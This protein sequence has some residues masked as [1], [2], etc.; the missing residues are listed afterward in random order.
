MATKITITDAGLVELVNAQQSGTESVTLTHI[1]FGTGQ[2]T[3][4]A[5]QTALQAEIKRL[6]T[7]A[8]G[9]VD[10]DVIHLTVLDKSTD[11][12]TANEFGVFTDKGTLFAVYSQTDPIVQKAASSQA[13]LAIDIKITGVDVSS[14]TVGDTTFVVPPATTEV[15]G[16][17]ELATIDE[18][19]EGSDSVRAVTPSGLNARV[20]VVEHFVNTDV[21]TSLNDLK[22]RVTNNTLTPFCVNQGPL[23]S[24]GLPN[25]L[26]FANDVNKTVEVAFIQPELTV[27]GTLGGDAFAVLAN[28][29][30][31]Y[32]YD[33][34]NSNDSY[35]A[36]SAVPSPSAPSEITIYNPTALKLASIDFKNSSLSSQVWSTIK[37]Q[38]S[39]DNATWY[40]LGTFNNSI[41]TAS[42]W[43]SVGIDATIAYKYFKLSFTVNSANAA[44]AIA[45]IRLNA[46]MSQTITGGRVSFAGPLVAT[47]AQGEKFTAN[48]IADLDLSNVT[49]TT[50]YVYLTRSGAPTYTLGELH[51]SPE[52]PTTFATDDIWF[53]TAEPLA[54]YQY[55]A[56]QWVEFNRAPVGEVYLDGT[57]K[58]TS[59]STYPY[60]QNGY[61]VNTNTVATASTF[62]LVRTASVEDTLNCQCDEATVTPASLYKMANFRT[63]ETEYAEG[64]TVGCPFHHNWYLICVTS[65][66]TSSESLDCRDVAI[67]QTIT[68]GTVVW[69]VRE[70]VR[71]MVI[72]ETRNRDTS[73]PTYG[74]I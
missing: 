22:D 33:A 64:D 57:G 42:T 26:S 12:Y 14:I 16:L 65:G 62:G 10:Q 28:Q 60:N 69:E 19:L 61:T 25:I 70:E 4:S 36:G 41:R 34:F 56:G 46:T 67:G 6:D 30:N 63:I 66:T 74:L 73:K 50:V 72:G 21:M 35:W 48:T 20:G 29:N 71:S 44:I 38:A 27:N 3:P 9:A 51:A 17:V 43:V 55:L 68:D 47:T 2:Y 15:Q 53:K 11:V 45:Q 58:I 32:I 8:G 54:S 31:N 13:M 59:V 18:A 7:I 5:S 40:D 23:S 49:A 1:A 24:E 52:E 37:V 39:N